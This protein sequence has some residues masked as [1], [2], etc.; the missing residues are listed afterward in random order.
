MCVLEKNKEEK[1][2]KIQ[3]YI[4]YRLFSSSFPVKSPTTWRLRVTHGELPSL[5]SY[6]GPESSA[7]VEFGRCVRGNLEG[8]SKYARER[9]FERYE[10][11]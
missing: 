4:L 10:N 6:F 9:L 8:L 11:S 7:T 1:D 2:K 3:I 5:Q